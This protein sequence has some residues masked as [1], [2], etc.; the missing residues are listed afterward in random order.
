MSDGELIFTK[1]NVTYDELLIN[2]RNDIL[3]N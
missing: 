2:L 1:T 3:S